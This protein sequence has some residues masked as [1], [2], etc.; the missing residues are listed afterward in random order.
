[1]FTKQFALFSSSEIKFYIPAIDVKKVEMVTFMPKNS[2]SFRLLY[3][4]VTQ[5]TSNIIL[6]KL[7]NQ[8]LLLSM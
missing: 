1:M 8:T 6:T 3:N 5:G 7:Q 2:L 4:S